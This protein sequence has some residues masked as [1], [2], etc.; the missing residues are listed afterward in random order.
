MKIF[1][2]ISLGNLGSESW[3]SI[4]RRFWDAACSF[5]CIESL[6]QICKQRKNENSFSHSGH[7]GFHFSKGQ[8][9]DEFSC[10]FHFSFRILTIVKQR[11]FKQWNTNR[12]FGLAHTNTDTAFWHLAQPLDSCEFTKRELTFQLRSVGIEANWSKLNCHAFF[13]LIWKSSLAVIRVWLN[14]PRKCISVLR[15]IPVGQMRDDSLSTLPK[16]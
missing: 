4:F 11:R 10:K 13:V 1:P 14:E 6:W 3:K 8:I 7:D 2:G 5:G 16:N 9:F 15:S 12:I